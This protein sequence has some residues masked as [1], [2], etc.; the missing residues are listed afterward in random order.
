MHHQHL[1]KAYRCGLSCIGLKFSNYEKHREKHGS[2]Q[3]NSFGSGKRCGKGQWKVRAR[4]RSC[5]RHMICFHASRGQ[6]RSMDST[7]WSPCTHLPPMQV[8]NG[9]ALRMKIKFLTSCDTTCSFKVLKLKLWEWPSLLPFTRP[10]IAT[11][12]DICLDSGYWDSFGNG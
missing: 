7:K 9:W 1:P 2:R 11:I 4:M 6:E 5:K 3:R 10:M 12:Q 8:I